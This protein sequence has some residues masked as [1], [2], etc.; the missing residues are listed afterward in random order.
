MQS[1]WSALVAL[2]LFTS[3]NAHS[4]VEMMN[5][6]A[7]NGTYSGAPGFARGNCQRA[8]GVDPDKCMV[9]LLP[10]NGRAEA[11]K[12]L[13]SDAMCKDTQQSP[14]QSKDS[15]R[16]QA[17]PG[18]LVALR[19]Q[20]NGHVTLPDT[21]KGKPANRGTVYIYGTTE[22][23]PNEKFLTVH[24]V[25]NP[26][27]TGGNKKGKLLAMQNYDDG[28]CYQINGQALSAQR[29]KQFSHEAAQPMGQD[30]WCQNDFALPSDA[31]SGKPYT[32]YWVWDWP[33]LP[34]TD[35]FPNG[36]A[37]I[38]TT[39]MDVDITGNPGTNGKDT[40]PIKFADGQ[41]LGYGAVSSY[42]GALAQGKGNFLAQG[43]SSTDQ[44]APA[45]Q[46]PASAPQGSA[47]APAPAPATPAP[48]SQ[49]P[50]PA[51]PAPAPSS[52]AASAPAPLA[53]LQAAPSMAV[54][55]VTL[56]Q[57][58][59]A[60]ATGPATVTVTASASPVTVTASAGAPPG[61]AIFTGTASAVPAS[62]AAA[63]F[64][65]NTCKMVRRSKVF[66]TAA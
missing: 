31:P 65:C 32:L 48:A 57:T 40:T 66:N 43:S 11:N 49:A 22:P 33:T 4:W 18:S 27:G 9:Q 24:K 6:I 35:G 53:S 63:H 2:T 51:P 50:A 30:L 60:A 7:P 52:Q 46:S 36:K 12:I 45:P 5:V 64:Q 39:C 13:D 29:Q 44:Q 38:Y 61:S 28:Q 25:W 20:E 47:P 1:K 17:A 21:Q 15:P 10:P 26:D 23:D 41:N 14:T 8:A 58:P 59:T 16:L 55:Q 54:P 34:G 42:M 62:T 37:E 3:S 19:Y 56:P